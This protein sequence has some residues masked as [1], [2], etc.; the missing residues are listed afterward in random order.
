MHLSSQHMPCAQAQTVPLGLG[1]G[2]LILVACAL[3]FAA[4]LQLPHVIVG[5]WG[6]WVGAAAF[7]ALQV[8]G[9]RLAAGPAWKA[10]FRA[11]TLRDVMI[12]LACV[13]L[14]VGMP[15]L[16]AL[17]MTGQGHLVSN[18]II[19]TAA[20]MAAPGLINLFAVSALQLLGEELV[21]ILPLLV[22]AS[23]LRRSGLRPWVAVAVGWIVT[24][25]AFGA[26]H[27]P[28][29]HWNYAQALLVIGVARLVLTGVFLLTRNL[30][31]STLAHVVNDFSLI[32]LAVLVARSGAGVG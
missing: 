23:A 25:L 11:P 14:V 24:S 6:E 7:V 21:T 26:L 10:L 16:V 32:A 15:L 8:A 13:P 2:I 17:G 5:R 9:W 28:T 27:L 31:A 18:A 4:L 29:Y 1:Q 22:L 3:A 20:G 30:W 12:A 19:Q